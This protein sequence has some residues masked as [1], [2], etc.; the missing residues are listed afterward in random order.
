VSKSI[1]RCFYIAIVSLVVSGYAAGAAEAEDYDLGKVIVSATRTEQLQ[2]EV[3]STTT[4][5]G[6]DEIRKTGKSF[7][8]EV[9]QDVP[10]VSITQTGV[11]GGTTSVD[12]RGGRRGQTLIMIDGVEVYDPIG[13]TR[14]FDFAHLTTDN[15]ERIEIVRGP[16]STL[17]GSDAMN[18]VINIIT[19]K[20]QG[21]F[22]GEVTAGAGSH[23][24][25]QEAARVGGENGPMN[26]SAAVSRLDSDGISKARDG[27]E[28]DGYDDTSLSL[29]VGAAF[30]GQS[31]VFSVMRYNYAEFDVDD[32]AYE[33]DPNRTNE[34]EQFSGKI[35]LDQTINEQW[36]QTLAVSFMSMDRSD[37]DPADA[38]DLL[39]NETS[40]FRGDRKKFEWQH[41]V[42]LGSIDTETFGYEYDQER[43]SSFS[44]G[45][46]WWSNS[47]SDRQALTTRA[48]FFQS[49]L[50]PVD[51]AFLTA[52]I[53]TDDHEVFGAATTY[54]LSGSYL[55]RDWKT[56][57]R[58]NYGTAFRAPNI[59]QLY[60]A[61]YGNRNLDPEKSKGF[62][63]GVEQYLFQDAVCIEATY[64]YNAYRNLID[65]DPIT[66]Q[67]VNLRKGTSRGVELGTK[68]LATKTFNIGSTYTYTKTRDN[69]TAKEFGRRPKN[70]A[71]LYCDWDCTEKT[72]LYVS[73]RYVG[74]RLDAPQYNDN[75]NKKYVVVD[76]AARYALSG[77]VSLFGRIENIFDAA[78]EPIRGFNGADRTIFAGV[79][80][81]F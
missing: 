62:D 67:F 16:Q 40:R 10:G 26:Y 36:N 55:L 15:V 22:S 60:D 4:V 39:E 3:G 41:N 14:D 81:T 32:G 5:I 65:S 25:F 77:N 2:G 45:A 19:R 17:Y 42:S 30:D 70:Q 31:E 74:S 78:Y 8:Y 73:G 61:N 23:S 66:W 72:N 79:R 59:Y 50:N 21:P 44:Q 52:G 1:R 33:D 43:G 58:A 20:G 18:G 46:N 27:A 9:L 63:A 24:T 69:D 37:R 7:V 64:F 49:H 48:Y 51:D 12:I 13:V 54:K 35:G 28:A 56:R 47:Q 53:R 57:L 76:V 75:K 38:L 29:R 34:S 71:A 11:F 80:A 68:W 6:N